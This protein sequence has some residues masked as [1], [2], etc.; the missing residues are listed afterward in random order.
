MPYVYCSYIGDNKYWKEQIEMAYSQ[1][2]GLSNENLKS[3]LDDQKRMSNSLMKCAGLHYWKT[4]W[5]MK[6]I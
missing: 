4:Y 5:R 6:Y 2:K 1:Y 3:W